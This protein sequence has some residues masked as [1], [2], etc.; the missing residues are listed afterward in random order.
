MGFQGISNLHC[1]SSD[2][3]SDPSLLLL[4]IASAGA[5][6]LIADADERIVWA[7][8][9]FSEFSGLP[10]HTVTTLTSGT[11]GRIDRQPDRDNPLL[12]SDGESEQIG[13]TRLCGTRS[14]GTAFVAE[15]VVTPLLN[16][17]GAV[18]HFVTVMHDV[19]QSCTAL[20][21]ARIRAMQ[22]DLTGVACRSH[23][24]G[25]LHAALE[26]PR[27]PHQLLA[28]LFIDLD[29]FKRIND[30]FGHLVGDSLLKAVAARLAGLVRCSDTVARFGGD[31]FLVLIPTVSG[32]KAAKV[33][34]T[35]IV[36]QLAQPFAIG[37]A[38]HHISASVGIAFW[39][40]HGPTAELLLSDA[41]KA[42]Y[43]AKSRGG[44]QMAVATRDG[45]TGHANQGEI[46]S[47]DAASGQL[48]R[49]SAQAASSPQDRNE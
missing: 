14:D 15:A 49:K 47:F 19:T 25:V 23:I 26:A 20:E 40:D 33:I 18:T 48:H 43:R 42:M 9:A 30:S 38:L 4:A 22:D 34:G 35:H 21:Q 3:P 16:G 12:R 36:Q 46:P 28:L 10:K 1:N 5:P 24:E 27:K 11:W 32:R 17:D 45:K 41:D 7:N 8:R 13:R 44:N 6:I 2:L 37:P 39:P 29:G 31:E